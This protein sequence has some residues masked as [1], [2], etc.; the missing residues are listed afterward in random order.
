MAEEWRI[1]LTL[2]GPAGARHYDNAAIRVQLRKRLGKRIAV[3]GEKAHIFLYVPTAEAADGATHVAQEVL[4]EHSLYADLQVERWDPVREAWGDRPP[5][6]ADDAV[7]DL[8]ELRRQRR[9]AEVAGVLELVGRII[10]M[11]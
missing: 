7:P 10:E 6:P 2:D 9:R 11:W 5:D 8:P 4:A 3:T 1:S